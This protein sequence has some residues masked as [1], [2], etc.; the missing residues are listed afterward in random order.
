M[1]DRRKTEP[2]IS[3]D[4]Y[5]KRAAEAAAVAANDGPV[6]VDPDVAEHMGAFVEDALDDDTALDSAFDGNDP[7]EGLADDEA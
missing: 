6:A 2:A 3:E 7:Q 4:D 5:L 1:N